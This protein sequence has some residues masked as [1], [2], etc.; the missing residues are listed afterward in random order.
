M[1][2]VTSKELRW[3]LTVT[4]AGVV[5][6]TFALR[7]HWNPQDLDPGTEGCLTVV[8]VAFLMALLHPLSYG[9]AL[10]LCVPL[11]LP[12]FLLVQYAAGSAT[13][14]G[15]A[16]MHLVTMGF[17]GVVLALREPGLAASAQAH[18]APLRERHAHS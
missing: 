11:V 18:R 5:A 1:A 4:G 12:E 13:G 14:A 15:M 6:I 17:I 16:G 3:A 9:R 2:K 8:I 7:A 10:A